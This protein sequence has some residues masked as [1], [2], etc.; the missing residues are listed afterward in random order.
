M[1]RLALPKPPPDGQIAKPE[2]ADPSSITIVQ[3]EPKIIAPTPTAPDLLPYHH[4]DHGNAQRFVL[5]YGEDVRYWHERKKWL[6]FDGRR[7]AVDESEQVPQLGR[8]AM[9]EF[10]QQAVEGR[11]EEKQRFAGNCLSTKAIA[12]ML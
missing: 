10:L 4:S 11:S 12:S 2:W 5:L 3:M 6:H 9:V 7:W 8:L 1:D